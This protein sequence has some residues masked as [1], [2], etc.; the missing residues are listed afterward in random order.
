MSRWIDITFREPADIHR[1]HNFGEDLSCV[2]SDN[3][4]GVLPLDDAD[5]ATNHLRVTNIRS[6]MLRRVIALVETK[7]V[8]HGYA[9]PHPRPLSRP[10]AGEGCRSFARTCCGGGGCRGGF[11]CRARDEGWLVVRNRHYNA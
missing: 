1:L 8:E 10:R 4:W 11:W 7:I 9:H 3:G 2:F 5:R 6:S